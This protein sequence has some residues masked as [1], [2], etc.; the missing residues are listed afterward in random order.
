MGAILS[1]IAETYHALAA[2]WSELSQNAAESN[3]LL[4]RIATPEFPASDSTISFWQT[5]PKHPDLVNAKSEELPQSADVV[6]IGS[7]ISGASVAYTILTECQALGIEKKVVILEARQVCSGATGR[8]GGHLKCS[9]YLTYSDLKALLGKE[10]AKRVLHFQ[11]RHLPTILELVKDE[12]LDEAEAREVET[13]DL[14]TEQTMW[15]KAQEMVQE[16]RRDAPEY[17]EDTMIWDSKQAQEV[18]EL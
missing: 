16:L 7:G 9:P 3:A 5:N 1:K 15:D 14:F 2:F 12:G 17:A 18:C 13:V 11:L 4:R 8:N 10:K 6:I